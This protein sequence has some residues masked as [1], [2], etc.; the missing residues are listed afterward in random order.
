MVFELGKKRVYIIKSRIYAFSYFGNAC[1][2]CDGFVQIM[3]TICNTWMDL[4][5]RWRFIYLFIYVFIRAMWHTTSDDVVKSRWKLN[6]YTLACEELSNNYKIMVGDIVVWEIVPWPNKFIMIHAPKI[7]LG[8][9]MVIS[10][11]ILKNYHSSN[12]KIVEHAFMKC[13]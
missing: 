13:T 3:V 5:L 12:H 11:Y 7:N 8:K 9:K 6:W 2:D 10:N 4:A 1:V